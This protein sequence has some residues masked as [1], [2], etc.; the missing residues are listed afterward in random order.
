MNIIQTKE[1]DETSQK[2]RRKTL[3]IM[4]CSSYINKE[5]GLSNI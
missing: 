4:Q 5:I 2:K 3:D 1:W